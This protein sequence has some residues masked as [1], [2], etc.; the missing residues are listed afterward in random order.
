MFLNELCFVVFYFEFDAVKKV[1]KLERIFRE[2]IKDDIIVEDIAF[3]LRLRIR[4]TYNITQDTI[5]ILFWV[6]S[7]LFRF[8][9]LLPILLWIDE[10][11][12]EIVL[13]DVEVIQ[14]GLV[15]TLTQVIPSL[16]LRLWFIFHPPNLLIT[17]SQSSFTAF[18][19][20]VLIY[21]YLIRKFFWINRKIKLRRLK[22]LNLCRI[23]LSFRLIKNIKQ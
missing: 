7:F 14:D 18:K 10:C 2:S 9:F 21:C 23:F 5:I 17:L 19:F 3:D 6:F 11:I 4:F 20:V 13:I 22:F 8:V 15:F 16:G 1:F 12:V